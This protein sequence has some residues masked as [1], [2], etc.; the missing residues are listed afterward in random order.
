MNLESVVVHSL[1]NHDLWCKIWLFHLCVK[2]D[3]DSEWSEVWDW[4]LTT[5]YWLLV[6]SSSQDNYRTSL[7]QEDPAS[8]NRTSP[9]WQVVT[10]CHLNK[11]N[12][13]QFYSILQDRKIFQDFRW[14]L[15][16]PVKYVDGYLPQTADTSCCGQKGSYHNCNQISNELDIFLICVEVKTVQVLR[17]IVKLYLYF[18]MVQVFI[19]S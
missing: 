13:H 9:A 3:C 15:G 7:L 12:L 18:V 1:Y 4:L 16:F 2:L 8:P 6:C 17:I 10:F 5:D 19:N 14:G 11:S